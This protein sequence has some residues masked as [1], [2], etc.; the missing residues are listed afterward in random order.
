MN[1][2]LTIVQVLPNLMSGGVEKGVLE[3]A[4]YISLKG[5][6]SIV[7]SGGGRMV[8]ELVFNG[9][10][11]IKWDIGRKSPIT[12]F[13]IIKLI[14]LINNKKIDIIHARSRLP[15]WIVFLAL[16]FTNIKK[17][18]HFITTVH[19]FN[20]I[21]F[22]S[23]IMTKGERVFVVS[24]SIQK[25]ITTNYKFNEQNIVLNYRGVDP[26]EFNLDSLLNKEWLKLWKKEFPYLNNKIVLSFPSRITSRKGH[27]DFIYLISKLKQDNMNI[28]GLIIGDPK[29]SSNKYFQSLKNQ[30]ND[31]N[32]KT[33]ITFTGYRNDVKNI[34]AYSDIV[35]SL[36]REP[37]SFGRTVIESIKLKTPFIGYDHGGVG[38]QLS[39]VFPEGQVELNNKE[40]LY[41]KT[42]KILKEKPAIRDTDLFTLDDML[43]KT[44][45]T[46]QEVSS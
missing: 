29:F 12:F 3:V 36:S 24:K 32:L 28:H 17:R 11:H 27:E 26:K 21:S 41:E 35:Y 43:S 44:L 6:E 40:A 9:S 16:K 45:K 33:N 39:M 42:K 34:I 23:S 7:I 38:E 5:H 8:D 13:Y 15:A 10:K 4:K 2:K 14:R 22:Y 19:G 1:R 31:S 18:P 37:E 30:V 46:Y 25:F 20:S